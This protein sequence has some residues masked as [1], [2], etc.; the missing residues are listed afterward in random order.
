MGRIPTCLIGLLLVAL[1]ILLAQGCAPAPI[2]ESASPP[3][4]QASEIERILSTFEAQGVK[5]QSCF[6]NG[7]L[8]VGVKD[9]E[10]DVN[11]LL[12]GQRDPFKVRIEITHPWGRPLVH[13]VMSASSV[14][15]V[16]FPQK[17]F[18]RGRPEDVLLPRL[19]P[20]PLAPDLVWS[21]VRGFPV[22]ARHARAV[23][24]V[25]NEIVLL[26]RD[27]ARIETISFRSDGEF[28]TRVSF[29][30]MAVDLSF[31]PFEDKGGIL[32][33][34]HVVLIHSGSRTRLDLELGDRVCN[35]AIPSSL[36]ELE[37]PAGY[38]VRELGGL[39]AK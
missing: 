17:R 5:V 35:R 13:M 30:G 22:I 24:P 12:V 11:V 36:F 37:V 29:P 4:F 25:G 26:G 20:V 38:E 27:D 19:L 39:K 2:R 9:G 16:A 18:Y 31:C 23:S 8:T 21:L 14:E 28:P 32:W 10:D 33:A 1:P 6:G 34:R 3:P 7:R 15:A